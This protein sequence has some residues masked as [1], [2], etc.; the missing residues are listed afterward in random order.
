M[1]V[2]TDRIEVPL[3]LWNDDGILVAEIGKCKV[4]QSSDSSVGKLNSLL[5]SWGIKLDSD[6]IQISHYE[7]LYIYYYFSKPCAQ[8]FKEA[9]GFHSFYFKGLP[10]ESNGQLE[11]SPIMS[12]NNECRYDNNHPN[13]SKCMED[14]GKCQAESFV[15]CSCDG[16]WW[17][18]EFCHEQAPEARMLEVPCDLCSTGDD[19][20]DDDTDDT[21]DIDHTC[22][23]WD[24]EE[25]S[26]E[27]HG[28]GC[29]QT[30]HPMRC[31][32]DDGCDRRPKKETYPCGDCVIHSAS[33]SE[34]PFLFLVAASVAKLG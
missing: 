34:I 32:C 10:P 12:G 8:E 24:W 17:D 21:D 16:L 9:R 4:A 1:M 3:S 29:K 28:D 27:D 25:S 5:G 33:P 2:V 18:D 26:C 11:A 19:D 14:G 22:N 30:K 7:E 15:Y 13:P 6:S 31:R 23:E 20:I